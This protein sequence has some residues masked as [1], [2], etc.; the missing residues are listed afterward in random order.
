[1][2]AVSS[3]DE[4]PTN[5]QNN[6]RFDPK[7]IRKRI[8]KQAKREKLRPNAAKRLKKRTRKII[9]KLREEAFGCKDYN[10]SSKNLIELQQLIIKNRV[11]LT[12]LIYIEDSNA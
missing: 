5:L 6:Q 10:R 11:I 4:A 3:D 12:H 9:N 7:Q 1:M 2:H 8:R